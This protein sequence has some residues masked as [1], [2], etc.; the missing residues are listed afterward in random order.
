M[1]FPLSRHSCFHFSAV[2]PIAAL[3]RSGTIDRESKLC[4]TGLKAN[5]FNLQ[6]FF[7]QQPLFL[8]SQFTSG[9]LAKTSHL[10]QSQSNDC[11]LGKYKDYMRCKICM[12]ISLQKNP[13]CAGKGACQAIVF[14]NENNSFIPNQ[15]TVSDLIEQVLTKHHS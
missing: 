11:E 1:F 15:C 12:C 5:C 7:P 8:M 10:L 4:E 14:G 3:S 13:G 6:R 2:N 9:I